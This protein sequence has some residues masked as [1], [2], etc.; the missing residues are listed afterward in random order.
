MTKRNQDRSSSK[1]FMV[2]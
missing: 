2:A 1:D